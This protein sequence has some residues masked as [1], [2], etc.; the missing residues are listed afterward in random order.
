VNAD[1]PGT[2]P[3]DWSCN[4]KTLFAEQMTKHK[5]F[6]T[7]LQHR[8]VVCT[9][10]GGSVAEC[11]ACWIEVQKGLGSNHSRDAVG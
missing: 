7:L 9:D 3:N 5:K 11:L 10:A 6:C 8:T 4:I 1:V 2:V